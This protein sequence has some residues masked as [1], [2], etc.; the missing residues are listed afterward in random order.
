MKI[1]LSTVSVFVSLV[2]W[3]TVSAARAER[4]RFIEWPATLSAEPGFAIDGRPEKWRAVPRYDFHP[5]DEFM[6]AGGD[7]TLEAALR[8]DLTASFRSCFDEQALY[9]AV[10]WRDTAPGTS[11]AAAGDAANWHTGGEGMELHIDSGDRVLHLA[12]WPAAD[13]KSF[14]VYARHNDETAWREAARE[15]TV[16]GQATGEQTAFQELKIP[17]S[18]VT[19]SGLPPSAGKL[20]YGLDFAWNALPLGTVVASKAVLLDTANYARGTP[21]CFLSSP[22][23]PLEFWRGPSGGLMNPAE[24]G[25]IILAAQGADRDLAA[26][27][28]DGSVLHEWPIGKVSAPPAIDG[29][30]GDWPGAGFQSIKLLPALFGDRYSGRVAAS[31]DDDNLYLALTMSSQGLMQNLAT[32]AT[33][34]GYACGD[35]IQLRFAKGGR[36]VNLTAWPDSVTGQPALCADSVDLPNPFLLRQGA[37]L[38]FKQADDKKSY[39]MELALPWKTLFADGV[40]PGDTLSATL[41]PWWADLTT[42]YSLVGNSVLQKRGAL[43]ATFTLPR[44]AQAS[45]GLFTRDGRL[46]RWIRQNEF[47]FKGENT[48]DWDGLDQWGNLLAAGDYTLRAVWHDPI[49]TD[50]QATVNNPGTPPWPTADDKGDWLSDE[51]PPQAA[52][53]D[54][55]WVFLGAPGCEDGFSVIAVDEHGQRQWGYAAGLNPRTVSLAV[56]GDLLYVLY[57]GPERTDNSLGA[58]FNGKNGRGRAL[59]MCFDKKTGRLAGFSKETPRLKIATWEYREN[60]HYFWELRNAQSFSALNYGGP[61]RYADREVA[62]SCNTMGMTALNGKLY[63]SLMYEH[64]VA[65]YNA[66]DGQPTGREFSVAS[67]AGLCVLNDRTLLVANAY[68]LRVDKIDTVSGGVTPFIREQLAAPVGVTTDQQGNVYVSDWA[69]SFQVKQFDKNGK[70]VKAIGKAGGRPW[71]GKWDADGMLLPRGIAVTDAGKLWVAEDDMTP[72]RVSVWDTV[73]GKLLRDYIGPTNYGGGGY[74]WL[75]PNDMTEAVS[76][77][78]RFKIDYAAKTYTPVAIAWRRDSVDEPFVPSGA[79]TLGSPRVL[80]HGKNEYVLL[81]SDRSH[82]NL[83]KRDGDVY[84]Q[85]AAF[86]W[87]FK[88]NDANGNHN[89][90]GTSTVDWDSDLG[91]HRY[92]NFYPPFFRRHQG[93]NFCWADLNGDGKTQPEEMKWYPI[94]KGDLADGGSGPVELYWDGNLASDF[95]F[96]YTTTFKDTK[97]IMRLKPA[98]WT[99]SGAPVYDF[100]R[101]TLVVKLPRNAGAQSLHVTRDNKLL[102][103]Y[104]YEHGAKPYTDTIQCYD[105]D[106]KFL[107]SIALPPRL[108]GPLNVHGTGLVYDYDIPGLG[109]VC[110]TWNWHGSYRSYMFTTK[111]DYIGS[112]LDDSRNGP[113]ATWGESFRG[114]HQGKDGVPYLINGANQ[115]MHILRL[116]GL[117]KSAVGSASAKYTLSAADVERARAAVQALAADGA[118]PRP[119]LTLATAKTKPV[120]DGDLRDWDL[121]ASVKFADEKDPARRAEVA[122][123][124]DTDNLYIAWQ[125]WQNTPPWRNSGADWQ[126]LFMTGDCVDLMLQTDP[127]ADPQRQSAAVGDVRLLIGEVEGQPLTVSYRPVVPGTKEPEQLMAA[128][129]DQIAKFPN[130]QVAVQRREG[131][132]VVEAALPLQDLG[133]TVSDKLRG[134]VG[135]IFADPTG[136]NRVLRLYYY[137]H[138]QSTRIVEDLTT[139]ATLQPAEWGDLRLEK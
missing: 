60:Y 66:A 28:P 93:E 137:N 73:S 16:S 91:A 65:E 37:K 127:Q 80:F 61:P 19:V 62:E 53:T 8:Q 96:F 11:K 75:D 85:V 48:V 139:E 125:V 50:Y 101:A 132:Y 24:W 120:I 38:V 6:R 3:F 21:F 1:R 116:K 99:K 78:T 70:L 98:K 109:V 110:L 69:D 86:G 118:A 71:V 22:Q 82:Y 103:F 33:Q 84:K 64:K 89:S 15:V 12:C 26:T 29:S 54:G 128:K 20:R 94:A 136:R 87:R 41:Q 123:A 77:A 97:A 134:D 56:D 34:Y 74:S 138:S 30:L 100:D 72:K 59:L 124:R 102:L 49:T 39:V 25:N 9:V 104:G 42:R 10:E 43:T 4:Y 35:G 46:Q 40:K 32:E 107:W 129:I 90:D 113:A 44:D 92:D 79:M 121:T 108:D 106:G 13:G 133:L 17:W 36:R 119:P 95:S 68:N 7:V 126:K 47:R 58:T 52:V 114:G 115:Q 45:L 23:T 130:A 31:Y 67:P 27:R 117:E 51:A 83:L 63:V 14:S 81:P 18:L 55:Q 112:P 111:G 135:A 131:G 5:L 105:F 76:S 2:L 57:G 88:Y 122:L